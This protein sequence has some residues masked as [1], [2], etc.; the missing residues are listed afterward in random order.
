M[1]SARRV[2][3]LLT[4]TN[5]PGDSNGNRRWVAL[6]ALCSGILMTILD[7]T[8]V[9][10]ALPSIA[11]DLHVPATS[12]TW[13]LNAYMLTFAGLLLLSGRLGD[14]YGPRRLFLT[15]IIVFTL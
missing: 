4:R 10:V 2:S 6:F 8:I 7:A 11:V 9:T 14:L 5:M 3:H 1:E 12:L 13:I 15:G